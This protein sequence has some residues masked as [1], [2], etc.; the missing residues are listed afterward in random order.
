MS[1]GFFPVLIIVS[2]FSIAAVGVGVI[3]V[4]FWLK[5]HQFPETIPATITMCSSNNASSLTWDSIAVYRSEGGEY[6]N[7]TFDRGAIQV[8]TTIVEEDD[9]HVYSEIR[10]RT[11]SSVTATSFKDVNPVT[12][13]ISDVLSPKDTVKVFENEGDLSM[14]SLSTLVSDCASDASVVLS[15]LRLT[16]PATKEVTEELFI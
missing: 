5:K 15:P 3:A 11:A 1:L 9:H 12:I 14:A 13:D 16:L 7:R 10:P 4:L 6:D 2:A 8:A